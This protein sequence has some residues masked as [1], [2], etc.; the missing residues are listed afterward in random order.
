VRVNSVHALF[1]D[2]TKVVSIYHIPEKGTALLALLLFFFQ[3]FLAI[4]RALI[5]ILREELVQLFVFFF[6]FGFAQRLVVLLDKTV[7]LFAVIKVDVIGLGL[8][9]LDLP[10]LPQM[11]DDLAVLAGVIAGQL[12][13][14]MVNFHRPAHDLTRISGQRQIQ[15][16]LLGRRSAGFHVRQVEFGGIV[17][18]RA[19]WG[20]RRGRRLLGRKRPQQ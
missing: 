14:A 20:S 3:P 17:S 15:L 2:E 19:C 18:W 8:S 16:C 10:V 1:S 13:S 7:V 12:Q 5:P 4:L 11:V 6:L 9:G